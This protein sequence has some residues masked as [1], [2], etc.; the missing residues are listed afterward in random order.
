MGGLEG[1][2]VPFQPLP[3]PSRP[4]PACHPAVE[5]HAGQ[6]RSSRI[7]TCSPEPLEARTCFAAGLSS[8]SDRSSHQT[9]AWHLSCYRCCS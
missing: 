5:S 6:R 2:E 1:R 8:S 4:R 7:K 9:I 3:M